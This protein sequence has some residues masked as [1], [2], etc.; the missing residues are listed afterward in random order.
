M[1]RKKLSRLKLTVFLSFLLACSGSTYALDKTKAFQTLKI[2]FKVDKN[3]NRNTFH[4]FWKPGCGI[5]GIIQ[6]PFYYGDVQIGIQFIPYT[7]KTNQI[8]NYQSVYIYLGYGK[9]WVL[10]FRFYWFNGFKFGN[11]FM[12]FEETKL[13]NP[14]KTESEFC[15]DLMFCISYPIRKKLRISASSSYMVIYTHKR[16]ELTFI[17]FGTSYI[18]KTPK[19]IYDFLN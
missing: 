4:D 3:I 10:P 5:E 8:P 19:W 13:G 2:G 11:Y 7:S 17:S 18:I 9:E 14:A 1:I 6:T 16:I 15:A 12:I